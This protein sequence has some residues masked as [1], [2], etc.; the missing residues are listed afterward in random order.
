M[1][2]IL[3]V[4]VIALLLSYFVYNEWNNLKQHY[5]QTTYDEGQVA[6]L[7]TIIDQVN[8]SECEPFNVYVADTEVQLID[9]SCLVEAPVDVTSNEAVSEIVDEVVVEEISETDNP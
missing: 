1:L 2:T 9:V 5:G 6:A 8:A 3:A 7:Q 4:I